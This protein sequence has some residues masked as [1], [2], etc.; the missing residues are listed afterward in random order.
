MIVNRFLASMAAVFIVS[1]A[2]AHSHCD[3]V[4]VSEFGLRPYSYENAAQGLKA[5]LD[6]CKE[7]DARVLLFDAGRYDIWPEGAQRREWFVS[8]T[9]TEEE[10]PS[11]VKTV[12]MLIEDMHDL[13]IEGSG[14]DLIFHGKMITIAVAHSRNIVIRNL[15]TDFERPGMSE[16][17][18]TK[19][20]PTGTTVQFH[21]DSRFGIDGHREI[22]LFGEGWQANVFHCIEHDPASDH[23][24]YSRAWD[25][26]RS[27]YATDLGGG[28][29]HFATPEE[30]STEVGRSFLVRDI[31]RDHVGMLL[32]E[33]SGVELSDMYVHY[34]HGLGIVSQYTKDITMRNVVCAPREGSGRLMASSADFM[35]FS[36]CSGRISV[37][38]CRFDG[39]Q[40]D[41]INVHGTNLR[42]VGRLDDHRLLLRFMHGQS[43]GFRAFAEQDS[44]AFVKA[45]T[46]QRQSFAVVRGVTR[47]SDRLVELTLDRPIPDGTEVGSDCVENIS[48][49]PEV[50]IRRCSFTRT[51]TR[52]TLMTTPRRVVIADNVYRKTGMSAI[53]IEGD[54]EGW[55]ESGP[56]CDVLIENNTFIDC[57][58]VGGPANAVIAL[59]PSNTEID[60]RKPVHKNV[61]ILNNRFVTFG[62]PVLYAKST[63]HLLFEGNEVS[64]GYEDM[65][66]PRKEKPQAEDLADR[67]F[68]NEPFVLVGCSDV[69]L[70]NN[71]IEGYRAKK[72]FTRF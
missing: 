58:Y 17:T 40:D 38:D 28:R 13:T 5:A 61:R 54:A 4:R 51:N 39:A 6:A 30:F 41:G 43:Y 49:T 18:V 35:H 52:G 25:W 36:G 20:D 3:T 10:C 9:S 24:T 67:V 16:M 50:E 37:L 21:P 26:L 65:R 63:S 68:S 71:K 12:G 64:V 29:V 33:S 44:V 22:H 55:F 45:S 60:S 59:H 62:N 14:A 57:G 27:W 72:P 69:S 23:L 34:M 15:H 53:L 42:I 56:V 19:H 31:I 8:N 70:Q 1:S 46:M 66:Q 32:L 11:K 47:V 48:A 2:A 7:R